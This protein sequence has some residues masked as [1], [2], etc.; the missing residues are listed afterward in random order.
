[1]YYGDLDVCVKDKIVCKKMGRSGG[2]KRNI[3]LILIYSTLKCH[4][5]EFDDIHFFAIDKIMIS[6]ESQIKSNKNI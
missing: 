2:G 4:L 5:K 6:N 3:L 1:M